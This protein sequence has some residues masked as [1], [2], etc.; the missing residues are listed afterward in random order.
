MRVLLVVQRYGVD[1]VG[2]SEGHARTAAIR[3]ARRHTVE[4]AT[5]TALD[6]WTWA[7]HYPAGTETIDGLP[8][9]RFPVA[10][11]R[12]EDF[13]ALETKVM[14]EPHT[15]VDEQDWLL[16]QGPHTP[17]LLD[18]L[19]DHGREYDAIL[20]YTYIYEPTAAGLPIVPERAA[21][22]ST[23]HDE[24]A[25]GLAPYRALFQLPRAF[26]FLTPE[27]RDLVQ[28]R[29]RNEHI[30]SEILGIGMDPAKDFDEGYRARFAEGPLIAYLGQVSEG[31]GVDDLLRLWDAYRA[32]GG[33]G[34]LAL[35][36]TARME[37]PRRDDV[38][39]LGRVNDTEKWSLLAAADALVLPSRFESLGIVLL[40]AWQVGTPVLVPRSNAVTAGQVS[41]SGGGIAY[42]RESFTGALATLLAGGREM[43]GRGRAWV[44]E[45]C[46][47]RAFDRRLDSLVGLTANASVSTAD[48]RLPDG[49]SA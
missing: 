35:A 10:A 43:G 9:H 15:L 8:V 17:A 47:W 13:K 6:Y 30:P 36:G 22:I 44:R 20:F 16:A 23:A 5:T 24:A 21:L 3:L 11:G 46:S 25:L 14:L 41:R 37:L 7:N 18:F 32:D 31:K 2:G 40:E 48:D 33:R 26:G 1:V 45:E 27:E 39:A 38:V 29:F 12:R 49:V 34:T 19:H 28:R 42:D 4:V